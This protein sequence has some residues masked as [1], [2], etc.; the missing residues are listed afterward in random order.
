METKIQVPTQKESAIVERVARIVSRVRGTKPDYA[1]LARELE[2]AIPFDVFGIV[3][4]RH[5]RQAVRVTVCKRE[6]DAW[7]ARH[8]QHPLED[9]MV[10]CIL[11]KVSVKEPE[12]ASIAPGDSYAE[13]DT[14][15]VPITE[16][17]TEIEVR[18]YPKGLDGSPAQSGDALSGNPHL[19]ATLIAPLIV[20]DRVLG[21][22]ELGSARI[23]AY[24]DETLQRLIS[25]VARVLAAAIEGAQV[26]GSVEIQDRQRQELKNVSSALT[27]EMDLSMIFT[28]IVVGIAKALNVASAIVTVDQRRSSLQL[29]AQFGL[30]PAGLK[31]L[32][33]RKAT[34][35]EQ[36]IIGFT[37]RRR[38]P[39]VSN[40][41]AQDERFPLSH[42][43]ASELSVRSIFSY[44]LVTGSTVYGALLL[45]SPEPGG[46]TPLKADILS[47]FASQAT[48]AIHNGMLLESLRERRRFQEAIEQLERAHRQD[49][50]NIE[51]EQDDLELFK[52]VREE[53]EQTFGVNFSSLLHFIS[54]HLLTRSERDLQDIFH[55]AHD[56]PQLDEVNSVAGAVPSPL[57]EEGTAMLME[58]AEAALARAGLL[59]DVGAA[60]AAALDPSQ[61]HSS[62]NSVIPPLYER[63]TRDM[64]NPWF[65]VDLKG[66]CIYANPAAEVFCGMRLNLDN[67]GTLGSLRRLANGLGGD[68]QL[69]EDH[70]ESRSQGRRGHLNAFATIAQSVID[71]ASA[72]T[73][74]EVFKELLPQIRNA[75]EI[76]AY[77]Q[78]F[79]YPDSSEG[80]GEELVQSK[81]NAFLLDTLPTNTL[82]CIIAAESVQRQ[83]PRRF[84]GNEEDTGGNG[85]GHF[86]RNPAAAPKNRFSGSEALLLDNAPSD[87]HYQFMRYALYDQRGQLLAHALQIQDI[88]EQVRDEKNKSVLLSTVSHDLRTPL[89]TIKAA[90]TGLLQPGVVW[91]EQVRQ[92][93]LED[94][95]AEADHLYDLVNSF[96]EMSRI[97]MGALVLEKEWCDLVE[98]V[99]NTLTHA[100]R[101]LAR[102][103]VRTQ[104]Q[105]GLPLVQVDYVQMERV[106][107]SLIE[108]AVR[109]SPDGIE[110]V[111]AVDSI[112]RGTLDVEIPE[113][114]HHFLRVQVIDRGSVVPEGERERIFKTF[115]SLDSQGSG[116]GLAICRGIIEAHQGRIWVEPAPGKGS[117]FIF[118]LPISS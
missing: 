21:T 23:N 101:I 51:D 22:L 17:V 74:T 10:E 6:S 16:P 105:A 106:F 58:T 93:V 95:D 114:L 15:G 42:A 87:R 107:H 100:E 48:I 5:D 24:A 53:A 45:C 49:G 7:V 102:H 8:H 117:C 71:H 64:T 4:L 47:L 28:R 50:S 115:Y 65:V 98:I 14:P 103:P 78:E 40:D 35:S 59:G 75:E 52:R 43:F 66:R 1:H 109:H 31:K 61:V 3:L 80:G 97:Q 41:I 94:I 32:L 73:M 20:E 82:R 116:L 118:V 72:L 88:T 76:L 13:A 37:L 77:L 81:Q 85:L 30:E 34:L 26:G 67:L 92:E 38:Q 104:F 68:S 90:V 91:D 83:T 108:N 111:I 110:I 9:S 69:S 55:P 84:H 2:P 11:R 63:V 60:L 99:H 29:E 54:D 86:K 33:E 62:G 36:A 70:E 56:V 44:P 96:I 57:R 27:S 112:S 79:T 19:H 12:D 39:C 89:T 113:D 25:A 46:F 18:N